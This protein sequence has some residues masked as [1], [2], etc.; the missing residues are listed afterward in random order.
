MSAIERQHSLTISK[1]E[2]VQHEARV[3]LVKIKTKQTDFR[4]KRK[5]T[6]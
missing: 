4:N 2:I 6:V 1:V 5:R 3:H